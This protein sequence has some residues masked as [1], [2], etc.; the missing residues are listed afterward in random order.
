VGIAE[1]ADPAAVGASLD[2][3]AAAYPDVEVQDRTQLIESQEDQ[4]NLFINML[5]LLLAVAVLVALLGIVNTLA[6]SVL[7]RTSEIGVLRAIGM[8]RGQVSSMIVVESVIIAIF[9]ALLG[10]AAGTGIGYVLIR[11]L[12][13]EGLTSFAVPWG[14]L[15][16]FLVFAVALGILAALLP[17]WR[18]SRVRIVDAIATE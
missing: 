11:S 2:E 14:S 15:L 8:R 10:L 7:E 5:Y 9:G 3:V 17:A 12:A 4:I 6:L 1:D 16:V 18:A 13:D